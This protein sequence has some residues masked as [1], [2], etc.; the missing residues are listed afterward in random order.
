MAGQQRSRGEERIRRAFR[1]SLVVIALLAA[2][3]LALWLLLRERATPE[4]VLEKHTGEIAG[5]PETPAEPPHV[6]F[7]DVTKAAGIDF[8]HESGATGEKLLPETMGGGVAFLD[9]DGDGDE[10]LLFVGGRPWP[11]SGGEPASTSLRLYANDG[12]G[13][14][15]DVTEATGLGEVDLYGM[16]TA[17]GDVEGDGDPDLYVTAVGRNLLLRNDGGRFNDITEAAGVAGGSEEWSTSAGFF[18]ADGDGDLD[19]FVLDYVQWSRELDQAAGFTLNG[20]DRAYGPPVIF[21]GAHPHLF[22]NDGAGVFTDVSEEAGVRVLNDSQ[23]TAV[24]KALALT[25]LD[26]DRD[27]DLDVLVA[28]DTVRNFLF[29]NDGGLRFTEV[30]EERGFAFDPNGLATGAM[31]IDAAWFRNDETVGV[32]VGNFA[33]EATSLFVAEPELGLF[34]CESTLEGIASPSRLRLTFGLLFLDYDLDG[35]V[36][37]LAA[38]G[39]LETEIA[40]VQASQRYRQPAQLFWNAGPEARQCFTEVAESE[41]TADLREPIVGRGVASADIDGDGDLDVVLTQIG[42]RPL[43]LRNDQKTGH[44]WLRVRVVGGDGVN[45]DGIGTLVTLVANGAT[46]RRL[47]NPTRSYLSQVELTVTFGLGEAEAVES[48]TVRWPDG[49]EQRIELEGVDRLVEVRR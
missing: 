19:L 5:L 42:G 2:A 30:G 36:D 39:H 33:N 31:G 16:G 9:H 1:R 43:L 44:H 4:L 12:R 40:Q 49:V 13:A 20:R 37:L 17:V 41:E 47:V 7:T 22:E 25:F 21:A 38:N 24:A 26:F 23:G 18:D 29:R 27:G 35:R 6:R 45:R 8:V 34:S 3:G 46:Q 32:A 28:N 48:M 15:T 10:D 11:H 14:F